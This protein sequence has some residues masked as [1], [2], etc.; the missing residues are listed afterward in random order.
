MP[1]VRL[2][3]T[4]ALSAPELMA[5]LTD[6]TSARPNVW[7]SIDADHFE[8]CFPSNG[9]G[10]CKR[11]WFLRMVCGGEV[12]IRWTSAMAAA[13]CVGASCGTLCPMPSSTRCW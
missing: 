1:T 9:A 3:M 7:P 10:S 5:V 6:F 11:S 4:S 8:V 12:Y 13:N 2:H